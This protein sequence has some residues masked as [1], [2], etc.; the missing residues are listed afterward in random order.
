MLTRSSIRTVVFF[1]IYLFVAASAGAQTTIVRGIV[2]DQNGGPIAGA[3]VTVAGGQWN[4]TAR[5]ETDDNGRFEMIAVRGGQFVFVADK[6][7]YSPVQKVGTVR[8]SQ[9]NSLVLTMEP[10]PLHPPAPSTG[11]LAGFRADDIQAEID[12]AHVLFDEGDYDGAIAA[13]R[14]TLERIPALTTLNLQIGH[15]YREKQDYE[16]ARAAYDAVPR[17]S[18]AAAEALAALQDLNSAAPT[19]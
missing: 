10:D 15:A 12:A 4:R 7:G 1:G 9:I 16:S 6:P 18:R 3:R 19:R 17:E 13:Y 11:N 8:T 2:V 5:L 14:S